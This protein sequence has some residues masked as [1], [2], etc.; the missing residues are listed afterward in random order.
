M[1]TPA[2]PDTGAGAAPDTGS[3]PDPTTPVNNQPPDA[4]D[5]DATDWK[6]EAEKYKA[7]ARK[8]EDRAKANKKELDGF[9]ASAAPKDGEPTIEDLQKQLTDAT[10]ARDELEARATELVYS[11]TVGRIAANVGADGEA[12]LDS[13]KFRDAVADELG[14]DFDDADLTAAVEKVAKQFAKQSRFSANGRAPARSGSP[15]PGG[16]AGLQQITEAELAQMSPE[17]IVAAQ[18]KGQLANLL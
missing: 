11:S 10:K 3:A 2:Q 15:M 9:K 13:G 5:T 16:P 1:T 6:A 4:T 17:Q 18:E 7:L 14:D 12:L 8:H